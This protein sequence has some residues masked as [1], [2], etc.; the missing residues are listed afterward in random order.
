MIS[1]AQTYR[2]GDLYTAPDGSQGIVFYLHPD[3]SGGWVVA[4]N[5][6]PSCCNWGPDGDVP[7]LEYLGNISFLQLMQD[8]AGYANT[9]AMRNAH[10]DHTTA[11]K[12]NAAW[13]V[14]L[15]HGWYIPAAGQLS[16]L[17][18]Q[19]P[20]ITS[21]II[22]AGG[23]PPGPATTVFFSSLEY[24][25]STEQSASEAWVVSFDSYYPGGFSLKQKCPF[26]EPEY[27]GGYLLRPV[28]SFTHTTVVHDST[29]TYE[30]NTGSTDPSIEVS[31]AQ[32][33][34]YTVTATSEYG[35]SNTAQQSI[36]VGSG[37]MQ[38]LYD[39]TCQGAGYEANGFTLTA[40]E[41]DTVGTITRIRVLET[42]GCSDTVNLQLTVTPTVTELVEATACHSYTWNGVT[43][44]ESGAHKQYYTAANGC[45]SVV[46]L[47]LTV[48]EPPQVTVTA[49]TD[50]VCPGGSVTLQASA[51]NMAVVPPVAIGDILC[52]DGSTVK[53]SNFAASGKTAMGV[54]FYVD[55]T[56][57]HGWAVHLHDQSTKVSWSSLQ[58]DVP[59]V[60]NIGA[61]DL[62]DFAGYANTVSLWAAGDSIDYPAAHTVDLPHGWYLPDIGQMSLL[63]SN[64]V[65]INA[66]LS[67]VNGTPFP[68]DI[69]WYYWS[70]S[71][72]IPENYPVAWIVKNDGNV[73]ISNKTWDNH[74]GNN[75]RV[76]SIRDF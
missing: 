72:D 16:I 67:I 51:G 76:R 60:S 24:W 3:G 10:P 13:L 37:G 40:T 66:S 57:A 32:T 52:T 26:P 44:Y 29:L 45:D 15:E 43:Y 73:V 42:A 55:S 21:K 49:T 48:S 71:E 39:T 17:F 68:M 69:T 75:H 35:C 6:A 64:I 65:E 36:V 53:P 30:W 50:T 7:E 23:T 5:D 19:M 8:T 2:V 14:D 62:P 63:F 41:T 27:W 22:A 1:V 34:T 28:R 61:T 59:G 20:F 33:T 38:T 25:T 31:P 54:V 58:V 18:N 74:S 56:R 9:V 11:N 70:S 47:V 46:T 4:L 12:P